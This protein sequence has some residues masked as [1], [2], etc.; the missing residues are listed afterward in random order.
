MLLPS[1]TFGF[2]HKISKYGRLCSIPSCTSHHNYKNRLGYGWQPTGCMFTPAPRPSHNSSRSCHVYSCTTAYIN[3]LFLQFQQMP[4][5]ILKFLEMFQSLRS[6]QLHKTSLR[7]NYYFSKECVCFSQIWK[8]ILKIQN[9]DTY[10]KS[11]E[12][13]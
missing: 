2:G 11:I 7:Q 4:F 9:S 5:K 10:C 12:K 3:Y 6:L 1:T 8:H 13:W